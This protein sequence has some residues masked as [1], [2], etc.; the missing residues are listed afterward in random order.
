MQ[1]MRRRA[2]KV[3]ATA[4]LICAFAELCIPGLCRAS[5]NEPDWGG[6]TIQL[7]PPGSRGPATTYAPDGE[8]GCFC[9]CSHMLPVL[10]HTLACKRLGDLVGTI[11]VPFFPS[12]LIDPPHLPPRR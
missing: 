2:Q 10:L 6:S 8:D 12:F 11:A 4:F 5:M 1:V 3:I 7:A 9:C